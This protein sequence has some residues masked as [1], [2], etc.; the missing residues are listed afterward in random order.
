MKVAVVGGKLQ[1]VEVCY[2]A[3]KANWTVHLFDKNENVPACGLADNFFK[4]N[5]FTSQFSRL[6]GQYDLII[7]ALENYEALVE[8]DFL[9]KKRIFRFF[10]ILMLIK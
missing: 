4:V 9:A 10:L 3:K 5:V 1:G 6:I 7:P 8:L 2:L